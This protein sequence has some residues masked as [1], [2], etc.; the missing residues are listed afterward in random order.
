MKLLTARELVLVA[1]SLGTGGISEIKKDGYTWKFL[2]LVVVG[3]TKG[4]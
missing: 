2:V 1:Q 4:F 3:T